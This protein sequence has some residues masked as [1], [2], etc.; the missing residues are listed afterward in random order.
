VRATAALVTVFVHASLEK[1]GGAMGRTLAI[2]ALIAAAIVVWIAVAIALG[3][4]K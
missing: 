1:T 4:G 3:P 2:G